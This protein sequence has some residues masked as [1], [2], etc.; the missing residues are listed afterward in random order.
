MK[1]ETNRTLLQEVIPLSTPF[2]VHIETNNTCNFKCKFCFGSNDKLLKDYGIKRGFMEKDTF[3]KIIND[4]KEFPSKIKRLYFHVMGEPLLH[5]DIV[6]FIKY[7]KEAQIAEQL[8]MFTNGALLNEKLA[9]E[10]AY[11][12]LDII[13]ISVEGVSEEKY[14]EI[15]GC[16]IDYDVFV[17]NI[18]ILYNE[19]PETC[20]LHIKIIDCNL[21]EEEKNK[22]YEDFS[23]I[24]N[25]CYLEKLLDVCP[26]EVM[27]TTM[28][29]GRSFTQEGKELV[30]KLVCTIPFYVTD[31]YYDGTVDAC[32][33]DWSRKLIMGNVLEDSLYN[34]WN[35]KKFNSLR[36]MQLEGKRKNCF[37]CSECKAILNQLDDIDMYS[38]KLLK[39]FDMF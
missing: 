26:D 12:G 34:I 3:E 22:F 6:H 37:S 25:E 1:R 8:V 4:M 39:K 27:D 2:V 5:K 28:G 21:S 36:K 18:K 20:N 13:Q 9:K 14:K 23:S 30:E 38:E 31:I 10:I 32:S 11:S 29:Y 17:D 19:K 33:C 7:A 15:T 24:S 35:G 16:K